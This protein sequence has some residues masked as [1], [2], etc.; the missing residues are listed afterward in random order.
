MKKKHLSTF[1]ALMVI[2]GLFLPSLLAKAQSGSLPFGGLVSFRTECTC[3]S[4]MT[5]IWFSPLHL[6]G[7]LTIAGPLVY[8]SFSTTLYSYY[9]IG[10]SNTWHLGDYT[11][12]AQSCWMTAGKSCVVLPSIGL[13]GKVG[14]SY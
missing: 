6:G 14:T 4:G 13:M 1:W 3:S 10:V 5:Y 11:P 7:P 12:G 9:Q 8:S 2:T